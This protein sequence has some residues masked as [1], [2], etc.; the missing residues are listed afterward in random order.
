MDRKEEFQQ[1]K[2]YLKHITGI[3][4]KRERPNLLP[5]KMY[6]AHREKRDSV[7]KL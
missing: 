3:V 6:D 7:L 4:R 2:D 1:I 5:Q